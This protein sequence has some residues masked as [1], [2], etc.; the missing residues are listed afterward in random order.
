M[1]KFKFYQDLK[2]VTWNRVDFEVEAE[3]K[4]EAIEKMRELDLDMVDVCSI[5]DDS[6]N[7]TNSDI[8]WDSLELMH[9]SQNDGYPTIEV[10]EYDANYGYTLDKLLMNN[11]E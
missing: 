1:A 5:M 10:Y 9:T 8:V 7:V 2:I 4:E 6:I 3:T 11:G